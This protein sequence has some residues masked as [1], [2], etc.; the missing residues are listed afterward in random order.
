LPY[1]TLFR[2]QRGWTGALT[3]PMP[4]GRAGLCGRLMPPGQCSTS[5]PGKGQCP[6]SCDSSCARI[7]SPIKRRRSALAG[8]IAAQPVL[9]GGRPD[10]RDFVERLDGGLTRRQ[11][12]P[13]QF[14]SGEDVDVGLDP[15]RMIE[16][17]D[18]PEQCVAGCGV[19]LAPQA[20]HA[21][22]AVKYLVELAASRGQCERF[23]RAVIGF[24]AVVLHPHIAH[25]AA[26]CT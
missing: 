20:R 18:P 9:T 6:R 5:K 13:R 22:P 26:A 12:Q 10:I 17:P 15:F 3:T 14:A 21:V 2:S 7:R 8:D 25:D 19:V 4:A 24:G 23:S 1:T 11:L 16:G